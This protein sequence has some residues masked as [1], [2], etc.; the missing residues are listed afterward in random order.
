M[1]K[2]ISKK[3]KNHLF[4]LPILISI[5]FIFPATVKAEEITETH[6]ADYDMAIGGTQKFSLTDSD[7]SL[8]Y[9]TVTELPSTSRIANGTYKVSYRSALTWE[10]S[11][12]VVISNNSITAVNS[13]HYTVYNGMIIY[14]QLVKESAKQASYYLT[15]KNNGITK[16]TGMRSVISGTSLKVYGI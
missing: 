9:V 14:D 5:L 4:L 10:A 3:V 15:W 13:K 12:N 2:N 1:Q 7:G 16:N 6:V 11:Y 8:I